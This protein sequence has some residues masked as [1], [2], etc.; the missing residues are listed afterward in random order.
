MAAGKHGTGKQGKRLSRAAAA[1]FRA[2]SR[3][4]GAGLFPARLGA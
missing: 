4:F 1:R 2:P 3:R